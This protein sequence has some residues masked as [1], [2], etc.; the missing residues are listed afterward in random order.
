MSLALTPLTPSISVDETIGLLD[1]K[2]TN[3]EIEGKPDLLDGK[4]RYTLTVPANDT[5]L[6]ILQPD[7][8]TNPQ[9]LDNKDFEVRGYVEISLSMP[10]KGKDAA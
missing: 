8:I 9:L 2:E 6:F 1:V 10:L 7:F 5:G 3:L 4:V